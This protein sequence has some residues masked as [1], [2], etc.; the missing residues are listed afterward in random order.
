[1]GQ[2]TNPV[3]FRVGISRG[4]SSRWYA[5][6]KEYARRLLED[7]KIRDFLRHKLGG[8][9]L[10]EIEIERSI[11]ALKLIL[12]VSRPGVVIGRGGS[13]IEDLRTELQKMTEAKVEIAV[14][15]I[16]LPE[17]SAYLIADSIARQIE[18]RIHYK[19]AVMA[20]AD[21]AME[22][23]ARGVKITAAGVL[24]GASSIHRTITVTRGSVPNQTLRAGI[25]FARDVAATSYGTIGI[26]VWV[27]LGEK[28]L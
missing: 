13:G 9:G 6:G 14:E 20:A 19:R 23:G 18:R 24:G 10:G 3:G 27:Y 8:A 16:R 4:W 12:H 1:M 26:K 28:E 11:A 17:V 22:R 15:E 7:K 25:D 5:E 2:K 21:R